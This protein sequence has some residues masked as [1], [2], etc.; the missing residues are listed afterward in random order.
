M[1]TTIDLATA[2]LLRADGTASRV[3]PD[4][5]KQFTLDEAYRLIKA[6]A[7]EWH[8]IIVSEDNDRAYIVMDEQG[9]VKELP[10][11]RLASYLFGSSVFGDVLVCPYSQWD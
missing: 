1:Q 8:A 3:S 4:D 6:S 10:L 11:N 5:G 2:H 7:V 9:R